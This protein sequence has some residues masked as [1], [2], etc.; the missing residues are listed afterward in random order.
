M[1]LIIGGGG[2]CANPQSPQLK[3]YIA[4][5]PTLKIEKG[6]HN[7]WPTRYFLDENASHTHLS[8]SQGKSVRC[9]APS[10]K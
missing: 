9:V 10:S 1:Y 3:R 5:I 8:Q 4:S 2:G 7:G 6:I